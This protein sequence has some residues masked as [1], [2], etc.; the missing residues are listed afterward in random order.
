MVDLGIV[1]AL[2]WC[3]FLG[4]FICQTSY[5]ALNKS[6]SNAVLFQHVAV[7]SLPLYLFGVWF[8]LINL[9]LHF[10]TDW[11]TSRIT[12]RLWYYEDK[13]WFFVVVGF[14]QAIHLTCLVGTY[15][16]LVA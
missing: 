15:Y 8:A 10:A 7:Y 16:W 14:D 11:V 3:H 1:L 13:H 5:M 2:V 9:V 6:K 12:S 4:D